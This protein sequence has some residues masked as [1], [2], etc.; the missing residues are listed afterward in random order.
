MKNNSEKKQN[1]HKQQYINNTA[2]AS[3]VKHIRHMSCSTAK[4][5]ITWFWLLQIE[6]SKVNMTAGDKLQNLSLATKDN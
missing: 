1:K 6:N 4:M 3:F 5:T 2:K